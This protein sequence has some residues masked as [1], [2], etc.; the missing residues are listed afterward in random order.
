[1]HQG[2]FSTPPLRTMETVLALAWEALKAES[3]S[4][5]PDTRKETGTLAALRESTLGQSWEAKGMYQSTRVNKGLWEPGAGDDERLQ[6][7][8]GI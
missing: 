5:H 2:G 6:R 7:R 1:M 3:T 8:R 4:P